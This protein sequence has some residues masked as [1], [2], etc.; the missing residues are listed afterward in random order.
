M[1]TG[2]HFATNRIY[3]LSVM[4][5]GGK[6]NSK[7]HRDKWTYPRTKD[8]DYLVNPAPDSLLSSMP[9]SLVDN[10]PQWNEK[11][12]ASLGAYMNQPLWW[13]ACHQLL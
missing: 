4:Q 6:G 11:I 13:T 1:A 10:I 12:L 2:L 8:F 9:D 7:Q 3:S 5:K